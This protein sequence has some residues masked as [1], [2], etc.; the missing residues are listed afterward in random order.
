MEIHQFRPRLDNL[1]QRI[2]KS[3][4]RARHRN[5]RQA[6]EMGNLGWLRRI[7]IRRQGVEIRS[8]SSVQ[9][10]AE[11]R[12]ETRRHLQARPRLQ[13]RNGIQQTN[14]KTV[15]AVGLRMVPQRDGLNFRTQGVCRIQSTA[16]SVGTTAIP[17]LHKGYHQH[18]QIQF[19][20]YNRQ[21]LHSRRSRHLPAVC[22]QGKILPDTARNKGQPRNKVPDN[23]FQLHKVGTS[24]AQRKQL[25]Q[26]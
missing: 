4:P 17:P 7:R 12:P 8:K 22:L 5:Q 19:H 3:A 16:L 15:V 11:P 24:N 1:V 26:A 10:L 14:P 20:R 23:V 25:L 21:T 18:R 6:D 9:P 2:R 13:R